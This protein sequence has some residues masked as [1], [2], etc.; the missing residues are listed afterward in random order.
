MIVNKRSDQKIQNQKF[1]FSK[2]T[3]TQV[4]TLAIA[5]SIKFSHLSTSFGPLKPIE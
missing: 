5:I 3:L 4:K 2:H 1:F